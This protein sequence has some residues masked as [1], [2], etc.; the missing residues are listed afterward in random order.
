MYDYTWLSREF[1]CQPAI[2][3][4]PLL[5]IGAGDG[6]VVIACLGEGKKVIA[7]DIDKRHLNIIK[8]QTPSHLLPNLTTNSDKF[9]DNLTFTKH[10]LSAI[11]FNQI[12]GFLT[13]EQ[14]ERGIKQIK[15][16][17][18]PGGKVYIVNY[19]PYNTTAEK[20]IPIFERNLKDG[21]S[22]PGYIP[23]LRD[24]CR[25]Q[26]VMYNL[27]DISATLLD[28]ITLEKHFKSEGFIIEQAKYIG[29]E[30][31]GVPEKFRIDGREWVAFIARK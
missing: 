8:Q 3:N 28:P 29:G 27:P 15:K 12:L 4:L 20:F 17:L 14:I 11:H 6:R 5:D 26:S 19:T 22:W 7:N 1:I 16:W 30:E 18:V 23:R 31:H 24:Y 25:D 2:D 9:A 13:P 10:S 21:I